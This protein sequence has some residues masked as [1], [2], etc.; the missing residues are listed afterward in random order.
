MEQKK[1][2]VRLM[3]TIIDLLVTHTHPD[4]ILEE[5]IRRLRIYEQRFSA[6]DPKSE[7]M[8]M[9]GT[10]ARSLRNLDLYSSAVWLRFIA[11]RMRSEPDCTG[12]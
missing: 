8:Q 1:A 2:T 11:D 4:A 10:A 5:A 6:N 12:R 3:G 7:L 9:P